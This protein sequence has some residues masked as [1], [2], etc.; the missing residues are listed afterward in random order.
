[1]FTPANY[2]N[3]L[4]RKDGDG[5]RH[6]EPGRLKSACH[7]NWLWRIAHRQM[8]QK[9]FKKQF[10]HVYQSGYFADEGAVTPFDEITRLLHR[11]GRGMPG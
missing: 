6:D 10:A 2:L 5:W 9:E 3:V 1:M 7:P 4:I 11:C 8:T